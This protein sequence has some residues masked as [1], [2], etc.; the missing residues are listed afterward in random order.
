MSRVNHKKRIFVN[1]IF[2]TGATVIDKFIFFLVNIIVARYLDVEKFGEYTTALGYATFFSTFVDI[3]INQTLV[4]ALNKDKHLDREHITNALIIKSALVLVIYGTMAA[5]LYFTNYNHNTIILTLIFGIVRIGNEYMNAFYSVYYARESFFKASLLNSLFSIVFLSAT[6]LV[7][8]YNGTYFHIAYLRLAAVLLFVL[9][10]AGLV[11]S[12]IKLKFDYDSFK[13]FVPEAV[14]FGLSTIFTNTYQRA[15]IIILSLMHGTL[16]S[17]YFSN[18]YYFFT[19]LFFLPSNFSKVIVPYLYKLSFKENKTQFQFAFDIYT[20]LLSIISFYIAAVLFIFAKWIVLYIYGDKYNATIIVLRYIALSI[21][22]MFTFSGTM[23]TA[24]DKQKYRTKT[25]G[26]VLIV[27]LIS[28][29]LLIY[30]FKTIGAAIATFITYA[31]LMYLYDR[32]LIKN[33]YIIYSHTIK[34]LLQLI[35]ITGLCAVV[36]YSFLRQMFFVY[37]FGIISSIYWVCVAAFII[38][39]NDVRIVKEAIGLKV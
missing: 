32:Y 5:S 23:I 25:Q 35:I 33:K 21:P 34:L 15:N 19:S 20:R 28:N 3:G 29:L 16:Y 10:L 11:L 17:G 9:L 4:R 24:L 2:V 38:N 8:Y 39:K 26:F 27:S 14:S 7:V 22:A 13:K 1:S 12:K 31:L 36:F 30:F 18:A 6:G 37:S